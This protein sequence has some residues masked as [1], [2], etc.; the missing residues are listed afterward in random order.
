VVVNAKGRA[1]TQRVEPKMALVEVELPPEAFD[2][3]WQPT[4]DSCLGTVLLL[5]FLVLCLLIAL[6]SWFVPTDLVVQL[7][8]Q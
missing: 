2:E 8:D 4:P 6:D 1:C 7:F 3:D 5:F